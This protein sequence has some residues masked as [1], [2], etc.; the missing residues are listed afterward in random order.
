MP[1]AARDQQNNLEEPLRNVIVLKGEQ[2]KKKVTIIILNALEIRKLLFS[3]RFSN[4]FNY[5]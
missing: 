3:N 5:D 4:I 1:P 2:V